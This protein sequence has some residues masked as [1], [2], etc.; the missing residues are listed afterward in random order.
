VTIP[1]AIVKLDPSGIL[2]WSS[3]GSRVIVAVCQSGE[4][5]RCYRLRLQEE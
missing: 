5:Q 1:D 3:S 4:P 2:V